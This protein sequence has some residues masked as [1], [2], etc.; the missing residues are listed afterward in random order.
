MR[1]TGSDGLNDMELGMF[2]EKLRAIM[3]NMV[4]AIFV[5]DAKS[6]ILVNCNKAAERLVG[7]RRSD[8]IGMHQRLLHPK[9]ELVGGFSRPFSRL[10]RMGAG[11]AVRCR[12]ITKK[13]ELR[14][15]IVKASRLEIGGK[16]LLVGVFN[17]V[18]DIERTLRNLEAMR[19]KCDQAMKSGKVG[20]WRFDIIS[21]KLDWDEGFYNVFGLKKS[22]VMPSYGGWLRCVHPIDR[23]IVKNAAEDSIMNGRVLDVEY[24][25]VTP[26]G[27][28]RWIRERGMVA[29]GGSKKPVSMAGTVVDITDQ[30]LSEV[31]LRFRENKFRDFADSLPQPA[32]EAD[33]D[34]RITFANL[35]FSKN[36]G[37][38]QSDIARGLQVF[39]IVDRRYQKY[40]KAAIGKVMS[41]KNGHPINLTGRRKDGTTFPVVG[42]VNSVEFEGNVV[43]IRGLLTDATESRKREEE[44]RVEKNKFH[45][46]IDYTEDWEIWVN[47]KHEYVYMSPSCKAV[48]GYT[49][50]EFQ[51]DPKLIYKIIHPDDLAIFK[52][53]DKEGIIDRRKDSRKLEY[54]IINKNGKIVWIGHR[55][56][57]VNGQDGKWA[58]RRISNRDITERKL[59]EIEVLESKRK[60][61][62]IVETTRDF[63][64][65]MD[66]KGTYTY[67]SPQMEKL[68]GLK[69]NDMVGRTPFDLLPH[70]GRKH[71]LRMF[72]K[73][74][75]TKSPIVDLEM[76]SLDGKGNVRFIEINGVPFFDAEGNLCGYRGITRDITDRKAALR[77]LE[78]TESKLR[79]L[80]TSIP[81]YVSMLDTEGRFIFLNHYAEGFSEDQVFGENAYKYVDKGSVATFK[82][83][84]KKCVASKEPVKFEH[85]AMG[86]NG[87]MMLYD[88][89]FVP[90][91]DEGKVVSVID[92]SRD[93]TEKRKADD[94]ISTSEKKFKDL[95]DNSNNC[96][97]IYDAVDGGK[98]FVFKDV[99]KSVESVERLERKRVIGKMVTDVF[100][101]IGE[102]GLLDVLRKVWKTGTPI[103]CPVK[104]YK[105]NRISG[106]R[107]NYVFRLDSGEV[108]AVYNDLTKEK[109]AEDSLKRSEEKLSSVVENSSDQIFMLDRD[110]RFL[111]MNRTAGEVLGIEPGYALGKTVF[112]VLPMAV[113]SR[114]SD[115]IRKVFMSGKMLSFD[116]KMTLRGRDFYNSTALS[117]VVDDDGNVTAVTGIVRD[118]TD[119]KKSEIGMNYVNIELQKKVR[120]LEVFNRVAVG[121]ELKMMN[122][123]KEIER[124]KAKGGTRR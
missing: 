31:L 20:T 25:I 36:F 116:E 1:K 100:P 24:R 54:R 81:D 16:S 109:V 56:G 82:M 2:S 96:I 80:V 85:S 45:T 83:C 12:V 67:C 49:S 108:V 59:R 112:E 33:M 98:D 37:Y 9:D 74:S 42:F 62:S 104:M 48:T 93:I 99:N 19:S 66:A 60:F 86:D 13:K 30:K 92:I 63:I 117:P 101:K 122:L 114:F 89:C 113:A 6:G 90:V 87:I 75:N 69:P 115:N 4:D 65:E 38:S 61:Q 111:T 91:I 118:I 95:F 68:W 94:A 103:R 120:E 50:E 64:W 23:K 21:G 22:D 10:R 77:K 15:V 5:A 26:R 11:S 40:V 17:D 51:E 119:R 106:W 14:D 32:I 7:R 84:F 107:E 71:A 102:F 52:K 43:G 35:S 121:R 29:S 97:A 76:P 72:S 46:M 79:T 58:G 110:F 8:I 124:I 41:G 70:G 3:N 105:D 123:K 18:T 47:P 27:G 57:P 88:S 28:V 78:A 55:C 53:H 34:G 44:M 39:K 73:L